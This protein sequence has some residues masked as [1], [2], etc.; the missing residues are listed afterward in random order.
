[1][2]DRYTVDPVATSLELVG[3]RV[4]RGTIIRSGAVL[5]LACPACGKLQFTPNQITG[6]DLAPTIA[7]PIHCGAG[8]CKRCGIWFRIVAGRPEL[9]PAPPAKPP[10]PIPVALARAGVAAP[11]AP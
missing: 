7:D 9:L 3:G 8:Y 6:P 4:P 11:K 1:M 10:T 2:I 5:V